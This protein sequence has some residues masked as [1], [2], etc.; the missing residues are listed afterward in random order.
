[1]INSL[2]LYGQRSERLLYGATGLAVLVILFV[3]SQHSFV[4]FHWVAELFSIV[5]ALSVFLLIWNAQRISRNDAMLFLGIAY[6]CVGLIDLVHTLTYKG[7]GYFP[8]DQ[9]ANFATELW[10]AARSLEAFGLLLFSFLLS[11]DIKAWPLLFLPF[12]ITVMVFAAIFL[13]DIF[14]DCYIEGQGLTPFKIGAEYAICLVLLTGIGVLTRRRKSLDPEIYQLMVWAMAAT[15][16][17]ELAFTFYVNLYGF[18]NVLG[19]FF[20]IVSFFLV[21]LALIENSLT[22]PY[23]TLFRSLAQEKRRHKEREDLLDSIFATTPDLFCLK[24]T[25]LRYQFANPAFCHFLGKPLADIVGKGDDDLF[26]PEEAESY[27]QGDR[28]VMALDRQESADYLVTGMQGKRWLRVTKTPLHGGEDSLKGVLCSVSDVS[29]RKQTEMI[30]AARLRLL[31]SAESMDLTG[32]LRAT[33]DEAE[34]L[35]ASHVGFYYFFDQAQDMLILQDWS[36]KAAE[37][38]GGAAGPGTHYRAGGFAVWRQCVHERRPVIDNDCSGH[39]ILKRLAADRITVSRQLVVPVIRAGAIVAIFEVGNKPT[40][41]DEQ[42]IASVSVLADL[43]WDIVERRR[44]EEALLASK[45]QFRDMFEQHTAIK[46][47]I[48]PDNGEILRANRAATGFYGWTQEQF[49]GMRIDQISAM[50]SNRVE[51]DLGKAVSGEYGYLETR[52][53]RSDGSIR[54]VA[55]H[56]SPITV[57]QGVILHLIIYDITEKKLAEESLQASEVKLRQAL[58]AAKAGTW[59]WD[60]AT[61]KNSWSDELF[62]LYDLDPR[63]CEASYETWRQ[64]ILP[65]DRAEV[66]QAVLQAVKTNSQIKVVWRVNTSDGTLR[67]LMSRGQPLADGEGKATGYLGTVID[68]TEL[69]Q[70]EQGLLQLKNLMDE[71]QKIAHLGSFEYIVAT[72]QVV[73]SDE[74]FRILGLEPAESAPAYPDL[75]NRFIHPEDAERFHQTFSAAV[76]SGSVFQMEHRIVRPDGNV[77]WVYDQAMPYF[78][79]DGT[80]DRYVGATLDITER[81]RADTEQE[82]LRQQYLQAQKM[83]SV[84]RLAGGVAHDFNNMLGVILGHGEL[85]LEKLSPGD[86]HYRPL[87]AMLK[88]AEHSASLT[89]QLL[90]FARKQTITPEV[91]DLNE[92]VASIL[93]ILRRLVGENINLVYSPGRDLGK[94]EADP[95]QIDQI[96]ANLCV[97]ACDAIAGSGTLTIETSSLTLDHSSV[98]TPPDLYPGRYAVL[99]VSDT[100]C[101]MDETTMA[102][103]FEPYFTTKELGKGT[104]LGL[105]TVYGIVKQNQGGIDV[106]SEEGRGTTFRIYLPVS[107]DYV[108]DEQAVVAKLPTGGGETI[109]VVEDAIQ[110][111]DMIAV[112]LERLGYQALMAETPEQGIQLAR[113]HLGAIDLV[114]T[115]VIMPQMNGREFINQLQVFLPG[116]KCLYMSGYTADIISQYGVLREGID[117]IQKPF[118]KEVLAKKINAA[119]HKERGGA[120]NITHSVR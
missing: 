71:G 16:A 46:L 78:S 66:E 83:E 109:L 96:L 77:R 99:A 43:A 90:A 12:A 29:A 84:G 11:R 6:L 76:K 59:E 62:H 37:Q 58:D 20:K 14:P 87:Q 45:E 82:E 2:Q 120:E 113:E 104:G 8:L 80:L 103:I 79:D 5:V 70:K 116:I 106:T 32:L 52:H 102:N 64:S 93:K 61:G 110:V 53:R 30:M 60:V 15:I 54:D 44:T 50:P 86:E 112:M 18:S 118:N 111:L 25:E 41:Y 101:G 21:Y 85:I 34:L 3:T 119:L 1:V 97:N 94:I 31:Q 73:W 55:V 17:A 27:R 65:K 89:R 26:P 98:T 40:D 9:A 47:M 19:H 39:Q 23:A 91:L 51:Q 69:K 35:T 74:E 22:R 75:Q 92:T 95:A 68:I 28:L 24:D 63:H 48:S 57:S 10:I 33:L 36:T 107:T 115:D 56:S 7:T 117:F 42:D 81:K 38:L 114:I 13:W 105:A 108:P 100:G 4:M 67:W 88:A 72:R 49:Q